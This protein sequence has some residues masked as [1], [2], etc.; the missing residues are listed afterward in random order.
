M[1]GLMLVCVVGIGAGACSLTTSLAGLS[2]GEIDAGTPI[3]TDADG[4]GVDAARD[5]QSG[6][7]SSSSSSSSSS[8]S[9]DTSAYRTLIMSDAPVAYYRLG[10]TDIAKDETGA[11]P[12]T[13]IGTVSHGAGAIAG[14]SDGAFVGNGQGWID[15]AQIYPFAGNATYSIEAWV[16]P[17]PAPTLTGVLSRNLATPGNT[18]KDGFSLYIES[19]SLAPT[20]GRWFSNNEEAAAAP[21]LT[22]GTFTHVVGTY[23]GSTLRVYLNGTLAASS[24]S[25]QAL[26]NPPADLAIGSTRN[27]T[28]GYFI[29]SL[30]EVAL[31]DKALSSGR[32]AAHHAA[33]GGI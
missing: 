12:G 1:R 8:G 18:P 4:V 28:Y 29:G 2:G 19:P 24:P 10:N 14:D 26:I 22:A 11:H 17:Q 5:K 32:I 27:G 20:L 6:D 23:D 7:G 13:V 9:P 15:V 16:A 33:G 3:V 30:D 21:G 31:Y 25:T